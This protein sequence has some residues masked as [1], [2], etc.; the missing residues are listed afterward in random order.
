MVREEGSGHRGVMG[1]KKS[2]NSN[3]IINKIY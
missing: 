1:R 3:S 2:D